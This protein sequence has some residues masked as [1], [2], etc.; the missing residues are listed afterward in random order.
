MRRLLLTLLLLAATSAQAQ[1]PAQTPA[2]A[3]D[4][5]RGREIFIADGCHQ[6]HGRV[7]QGG[8]GPALAAT[9]LNWTGYSRQVRNPIRNMPPYSAKVMPEQDLADTFAYVK[10]LSGVMTKPPAIL[11]D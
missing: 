10:G 8:P 6:C 1:A 11:S 9:R 3:G 5:K 2:P 7:G 4:A